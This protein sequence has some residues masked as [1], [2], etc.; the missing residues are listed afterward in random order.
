MNVVDKSTG[1]KIYYKSHD[2]A[3]GLNVVY[4][5]VGDDSIYYS[6][7]TPASSEIDAKG[8]YYLNFISPNKNLYL[9]CKIGLSNGTE[10]RGLILRVGEPIQQ[11]LFYVDD[12]FQGGKTLGY[13]VFNLNGDILQNGNLLDEYNTGFY[14]ADVTSLENG[15]YFFKVEPYAAKFTIPLQVENGDPV[16]ITEIRYVTVNVSTSKGG[17][18]KA[19]HSLFDYEGEMIKKRINAQ[20]KKSEEAKGVMVFLSKDEDEAFKNVKAALLDNSETDSF[21]KRINT[22]VLTK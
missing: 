3:S 19:R 18:S 10:N 15:T 6:L 12:R 7:N 5:I 16:V 8:V 21:F 1:V 11:K 4:N 13:E 17:A 14:S 20:L 9:M 2:L 22:N